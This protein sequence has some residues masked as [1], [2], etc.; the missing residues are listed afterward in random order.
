MF[1]KKVVTKFQYKNS[2][3]DFSRILPIDYRKNTIGTC[4]GKHPMYFPQISL[5]TY[6]FYYIYIYYI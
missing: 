2:S 1:A 4:L 6:D 5:Y 3:K